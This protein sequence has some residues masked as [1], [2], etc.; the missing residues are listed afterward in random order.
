MLAD[1]FMPD[2][3]GQPRI[4]SFDGQQSLATWLRLVVSRRAINHGTLKWNSFERIDRLADIVD[5]TATNRIEA[6]IRAHRFEEISKGCFIRASES[7]TDHERLIV[8]MHYEQGLR[9]VE[10]ARVLD[11]HPSGVSRQLRRVHDKLQR[12]IVSVLAV[13]HQLGPA[14]ISECLVY[15]LENPEHSLLAIIRTWADGDTVVSKHG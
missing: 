1:L 8:L 10:V 3:S 4:A 6:A 9:I 5:Q 14:A 15:M 7:L 12:E 13:E 11:I 2:S